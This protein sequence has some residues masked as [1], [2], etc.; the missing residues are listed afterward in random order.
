MMAQIGGLYIQCQ[1]VGT[2]TTARGRPRSETRVH[3]ANAKYPLG[4]W[5]EEDNTPVRITNH[6]A[7]S[8]VLENRRQDPGVVEAHYTFLTNPHHLSS[9]SYRTSENRSRKPSLPCQD[10]PAARSNAECLP[11]RGAAHICEV[12]RPPSTGEIALP[13]VGLGSRSVRSVVRI[14]TSKTVILRPS[15]GIV[16]ETSRLKHPRHHLSVHL[17]THQ[18]AST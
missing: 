7:H 18:T 8:E 15:A 4:L 5:A 9:R 13:R 12:A 11:W 17:T 6:H 10:S 14:S 1:H 2:L 3:R 16:P